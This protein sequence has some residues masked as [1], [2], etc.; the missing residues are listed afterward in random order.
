[1][2][3]FEKLR[4][5]LILIW[6][7]CIKWQILC[8]SKV[9]GAYLS[10]RLFYG[11]YAAKAAVKIYSTR[12]YSMVHLHMP[13]KKFLIT[14]TLLLSQASKN[15]IQAITLP[16]LLSCPC[17]SHPDWWVCYV[18]N[19]HQH[20]NKNFYK[21]VAKNA[22]KVAPKLTELKI[23]LCTPKL[24]LNDSHSITLHTPLTH[25]LHLVLVS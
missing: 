5:I 22:T 6:L 7:Q 13:A 3:W 1:M 24:S 23:A 21:S 16:V 18:C 12:K 15:F 25:F 2:H 17:P 19:E 20:Y 14:F 9:M 11:F 8:P 4:I 10:T